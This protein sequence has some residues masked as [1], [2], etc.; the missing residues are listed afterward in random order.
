VCECLKRCWRAVVRGEGGERVFRR[1]RSCSLTRADLLSLFIRRRFECCVPRAVYSVFHVFIAR[2]EVPA[3][4]RAKEIEA[5]AGM[6]RGLLSKN[7]FACGESI[8]HPQYS[9]AY[10][11]IDR[12]IL[13]SLLTHSRALRS[14]SFDI[15]ALF[16]FFL[17]FSH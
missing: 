4:A 14:S 13:L 6:R 12:Y 16:F 5:Q 2:V 17:T 1:K 15:A 7:T 9:T 11:R 3:S 10:S 8:L